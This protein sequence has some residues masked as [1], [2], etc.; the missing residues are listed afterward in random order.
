[1]MR[2]GLRSVVSGSCTN[3]KD[4]AIARS[5]SAHFKLLF[6]SNGTGLLRTGNLGQTLF[7]RE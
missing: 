4:C 5:D 7:I 6:D 3:E 1:M 2:E